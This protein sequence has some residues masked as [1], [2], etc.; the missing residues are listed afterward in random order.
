M[1]DYTVPD[2]E[3]VSSPNTSDLVAIFPANTTDNRIFAT[4]VAHLLGSIP[5]GT[6][7]LSMLA[8]AVRNS[9]SGGFTIG[10]SPPSTAPEGQMFLL[11]A[12]NSSLANTVDTNGST[13]KTTG[14]K[15]D[16]FR[17]NSNSKWQ[18]VGFIGDTA[19]SQANIYT[20]VK[21]VLDHT[22][23]LTVTADDTNN[24]LDIASVK[25]IGSENLGI[26][27]AN[28]LY[29]T[30]ISA[31]GYL[32]DKFM[33]GF[34]V[35]QASESNSIAW[36]MGDDILGVTATVNNTAKS[37]ANS[38][39]IKLGD[40]D[41]YVGRKSDGELLFGASSNTDDPSPLRVFVMGVVL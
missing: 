3:T 1:S 25:R 7:T 9:L 18:Y 20:A 6:I 31:S 19:S 5:A 28:T 24:E 8:T 23:N 39:A 12:A 35:K 37:T 27:Q 22:G 40:S 21:G 34:Q 17:R 2:S 26:S 16:L 30:D 14:Q 29:E 11:T 41:F 36:V 32:T 10:G 13:V 38:V 33:L 15:L 4:T